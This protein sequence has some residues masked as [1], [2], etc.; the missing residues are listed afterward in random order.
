MEAQYGKQAGRGSVIRT[1]VPTTRRR[2]QFPP[3][4]QTRDRLACRAG[5]VDGPSVG[6]TWRYVLVTPDGGL[7]DALDLLE[8]VAASPR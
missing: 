6:G 7:Q 4:A 3:L 8:G 5:P 2:T 1:F